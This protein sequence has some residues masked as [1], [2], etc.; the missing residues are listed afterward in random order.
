MLPSVSLHCTLPPSNSIS[1]TH[2]LTRSSLAMTLCICVVEKATEPFVLPWISP[3]RMYVCRISKLGSAILVD[4][5]I[6]RRASIRSP[7]IH[8]RPNGVPAPGGSRPLEREPTEIIEPED[9]LP[10]AN[11]VKP[12]HERP[13]AKPVGPRI[14]EPTYQAASKELPAPQYLPPMPQES[15]GWRDDWSEFA[16]EAGLRKSGSVSE[17]TIGSATTSTVSAGPAVAPAPPAPTVPTLPTATY[18]VWVPTKRNKHARAHSATSSSSKRP[19][20]PTVSEI[21]TP[22]TESSIDDYL[23]PWS[24][25]PTVKVFDGDAKE[26]TVGLGITSPEIRPSGSFKR[27]RK[28]TR[29]RTLRTPEPLKKTKVAAKPEKNLLEVKEDKT[30]TVSPRVPGSFVE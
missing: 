18:N 10:R 2:R 17:F 21:M 12:D 16:G 8:M 29:A 4:D 22:L 5:S 13:G 28:P 19:L 26:G 14:P 27:E 24:P 25:A 1:M 7:Q 30:K 9:A 23:G 11:Y 20:L 3:S 15:R 6:S